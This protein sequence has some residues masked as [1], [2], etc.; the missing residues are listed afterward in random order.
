MKND[1]TPEYLRPRTYA[2]FL[3][4]CAILALILGSFI[5][6]PKKI[7]TQ[8]EPFDARNEILFAVEKSPNEVVFNSLSIQG[9]LIQRGRYINDAQDDQATISSE[10]ILDSQISTSSARFALLLKNEVL[11][12]SLPTFTT[13]S[14]KGAETFDSF[15]WN[16]SGTHLI[17]RHNNLEF[18]SIEAS[19]SSRSAMKIAALENE[20]RKF[21]LQQMT[22][23][24]L[25]NQPQKLFIS[26]KD[27]NAPLCLSGNCISAFQLFDRASQTLTPRILMSSIGNN[28]AIN[29]L[30]PSLIGDALLLGNNQNDIYSK[31][32]AYVGK[33]ISF[34]TRTAKSEILLEKDDQVFF[35]IQSLP[36]DKILAAMQPT[37]QNPDKQ[38]E[39]T[40]VIIDPESKQIEVT[41]I[42]TTASVT[43]LSA[44]ILVVV[45]P[46]GREL[47]IYNIPQK[48][49]KK[50]YSSDKPI[51][52]ISPEL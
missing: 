39:S 14:I 10:R 21:P 5:F 1:E 25:K 40:Y 20:S 29:T 50:L 48:E 36:G 38:T 43:P 13:Q 24:P 6:A 31:N 18:E 12:V 32:T 30:S 23:T 35:S 45:S 8:H 2:P 17:T 9:D 26:W 22:L 27:T 37:Q 47:N 15:F 3:I 28:V 33:I 49:L 7:V 4:T 41:S 51:Y 19:T 16:E 34:D 44:D 11:M 42:P 52:L 46:D